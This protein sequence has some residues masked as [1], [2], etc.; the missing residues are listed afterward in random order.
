MY[1][2]FPIEATI[3]AAT[4][5][6]LTPMQRRFADLLGALLTSLHSNTATIRQC[7][8]NLRHY[9]L[10]PERKRRVSITRAKQH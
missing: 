9:N 10:N 7:C 6:A 1:L 3:E 5:A 8:N 4:Q 2:I